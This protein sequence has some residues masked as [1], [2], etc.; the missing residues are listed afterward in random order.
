MRQVVAFVAAL[1][2][3][4]GVFAGTEKPGPH[5]GFVR[6]ASAFQLEVLPKKNGYVVFLLDKNI[7]HPTVKDS[8][9]KATIV[10]GK[11]DPYELICTAQTETFFCPAPPTVMQQ[12]ELVILAA[13]M[14]SMGTR[15]RYNL[16]LFWPDTYSD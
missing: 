14:K 12:G 1:C 11:N 8:A 3:M 10:N 13:R 16:P 4:G 7:E 6:S 5:H 9:L 15:V 2:V